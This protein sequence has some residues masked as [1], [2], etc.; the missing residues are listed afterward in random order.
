MSS[1][2]G[3]TSVSNCYYTFRNRN[4][5]ISPSTRAIHYS[6]SSEATNQISFYSHTLG[7]IGKR[8]LI[9]GVRSTDSIHD[10]LVTI[11]DLDGLIL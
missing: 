9:Q 8:N 6:N 10:N 4:L 1:S 3:E 2:Y 11:E 7:G 5:T